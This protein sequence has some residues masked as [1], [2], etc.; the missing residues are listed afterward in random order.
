LRET[1]RS[2][3]K[4]EYMKFHYPELLHGGDYNPEQWMEQKD[5]IWKQD[6]QYAREAG[7]NTLS[8]GIF[9]WAFLEPED[10]VYDFSWMDEVMDNLAANGI[11]AVL[12]TPSGARPAWLAKKYPSVLRMT[13]ERLPNVFGGRHN[14]CYSSPDYER[15]VTEINTRLAERYKDHPALMM[16]H[17]SNEYNND[18]HCPRCQER[19]RD[20]CKARYGTIENLNRA[21]WN[22]FW[23]HKYTSFDEIISPSPLGEEENVA[24]LLAWRRFSSDNLVRFFKTEIEPLRRITPDVP[25]TANLMGTFTGLDY[26]ALGRAMDISSWD[27]Y[28]AWVG[29]ERDL[30]IA[31]ISAFK[32]DLMRGVCDQKP[33]LMMESS[34]SSVNWHTI[35]P[36][37][38]PGTILYQ[39]MQAIAHGSDSVQYFQFRAGRGGSEQYHGA[40]IDRTGTNRTRTFREVA[41]V[42]AALKQLKAVA[43]SETRNQIAL[44]YDWHV[45]WAV[46]GAWMLHRHHEK[47]EET[48]RDFHIELGRLG[49]GVDMV[50]EFSDLGSYKVLIAPMA[51]IMRDGFGDRLKAFVENGG[52]LITTYVTGYVNDELLT[53][54]DADPSPVNE[55]T[56]MHVDECDALD[57]R[58]FGHFNWNG[59]KYRIKEIA[60]LATPTTAQTLAVY[61]D[62]FYATQPCFTVNEYGKGRCYYIAARTDADFLHDALSWIFDEAKLQ[63]I[64]PKL[65]EGTWA[66]ER[67]QED[68]TR[69]LFVQN[70]THEKKTVTLPK[71]MKEAA[72]GKMIYEQLEL[73]ELSVAVL[74]DE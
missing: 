56:G 35:N 49:Y 64:L 11:K 8:I 13:A 20:W 38:K 65:P 51:Y 52:T 24:H 62:R 16:W 1:R 25:V 27:N 45:R 57:D 43:G 30:A 7:I 55:I 37:R 34:P 23:S 36:L 19:F 40:V 29:D 17:V 61:A 73:G 26:Y 68:G 22:S 28:P 48:V 12:A 41:E 74:T 42:G 18:C 71:A 9:S 60:E 58:T 63:P 14:A 54:M 6:M 32:H 33:F 2:E 21:W 72:T 10:G 53:Y 59:K 44:L 46:D 5:T 67:Y 3:R 39:G 4:E 69:F 70:G 31:R 50:D 15:K 66:T 47:Y